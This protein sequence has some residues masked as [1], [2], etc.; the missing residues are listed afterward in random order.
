MNLPNVRVF[1]AELTAI[2]SRYKNIPIQVYFQ[3]YLSPLESGQHSGG[4]WQVTGQPPRVV[5]TKGSAPWQ[6]KNEE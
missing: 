6:H 4:V 5:K 3:E 1:R 2:Y